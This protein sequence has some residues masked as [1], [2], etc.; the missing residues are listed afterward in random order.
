MR[1]LRLLLPL[2]LIGICLA[3]ADG[4][5]A[6]DRLA[7]LSP[8]WMLATVVLLNAVTLLSALRWR[9]TAGA[10]G[11]H[12]PWWG[13]AREYYLAQFVN[14]TL[15]GGVLGDAARAARNRQGGTLGRAAQ[16]VVL[17]RASGQAGMAAMLALGLIGVALPSGPGTTGTA[18]A[19]G[20]TGPQ[21]PLVVLL[22]AGVLALMLTATGVLIFTRAG[23]PDG[24]RAAARS[25][26]LG[27]FPAQAALSLAISALIVAGFVTAAR[28]S[29]STL[30]SG[31][32]M[33]IVPL[34]LTA[35][36]LPASVAGW[37]WREGA[38]AALFPLAGLGADAGL[39]A[40]IAFG[41]AALISALPGAFFLQRRTSNAAP[42][43]DGIATTHD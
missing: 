33:L 41:L 32:A 19:A 30:P 3:L 9:V 24:W 1:W 20:A 39:A 12:M 35:M 15:P 14:Q 40:S 4:Q 17:E 16:A 10:L 31:T 27:R 42:A 38:A 13:T 26:L 37:G 29:G 5:G 43:G 6:L 25:A 22:P 23:R 36:L 8:G 21:V 2:V 34:I 18:Y 7:A 11:L 28:A